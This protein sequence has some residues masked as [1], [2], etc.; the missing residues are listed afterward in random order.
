MVTDALSLNMRGQEHFNQ[1]I[2]KELG[3]QLYKADT[4]KD[5]AKGEEQDEAGEEAS[6]E[7]KEATEYSGMEVAGFAQM[8]I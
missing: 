6:A 5:A 2:S 7:G 8:T 4:P 3:E 1:L